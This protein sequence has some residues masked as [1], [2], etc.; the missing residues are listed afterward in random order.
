MN[1]DAVDDVGDRVRSLAVDGDFR[2]F[3]VDLQREAD[4]DGAEVE[5]ADL[6]GGDRDQA[7]LGAVVGAG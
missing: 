1:R 4:D 7:E 3:G 2:G 5:G 6:G